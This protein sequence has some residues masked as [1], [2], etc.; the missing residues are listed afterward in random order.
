MAEAAKLLGSLTLNRKKLLRLLDAEIAL[1]ETKL[2]KLRLEEENE[3]KMRFAVLFAQKLYL[4]NNW[5][6]CKE[7]GKDAVIPEACLESRKKTG[8]CIFEADFK[9]LEKLPWSPNK[10]AVE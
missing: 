7:C 5:I 10:E 6:E 4:R 8:K 3:C 2:E 1:A 9:Q